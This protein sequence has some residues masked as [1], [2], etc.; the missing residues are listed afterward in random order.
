MPIRVNRELR[1]GTVSRT[2]LS[3]TGFLPEFLRLL[4]DGILKALGEAVETPG[5]GC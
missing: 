3:I 2:Y 5:G 4:V 1:I